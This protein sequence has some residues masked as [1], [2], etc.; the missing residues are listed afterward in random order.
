ME[1]LKI[2]TT[3][4]CSLSKTCELASVTKEEVGCRAWSLWC[5]KIRKQAIAILEKSILGNGRNTNILVAETL[6]SELEMI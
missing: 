2:N 5:L 4:L 1:R 3:N 6:Q